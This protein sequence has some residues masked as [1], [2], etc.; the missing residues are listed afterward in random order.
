MSTTKSRLR[1]YNPSLGDLETDLK[2]QYNPYS[3]INILASP[4]GFLVV[5][6]AF[7]FLGIHYGKVKGWFER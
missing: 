1:V 7:V 3:L 4:P 2:K 5:G 6:S